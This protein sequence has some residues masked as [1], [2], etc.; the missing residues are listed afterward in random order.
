MIQ[1][2]LPKKKKSKTQSQTSMALFVSL[3][4]IGQLALGEMFQRKSLALLELWC[5]D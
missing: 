5:E 2:A 1:H 3:T 4:M